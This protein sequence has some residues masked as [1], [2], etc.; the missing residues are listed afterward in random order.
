MMGKDD[1]NQEFLRKLDRFDRAG[2]R[3]MS[4]ILLA[5]YILFTGGILVGTVYYGVREFQ[6]NGDSEQL[7][8]CCAMLLILAAIPVCG[9]LVNH[10]FKSLDQKND[11]FDPRTM[12]LPDN[13]TVTLE[14]TL[15]RMSTQTGAIVWDGILGCVAFSL[16]LTLAMGIGNR[17][18]VL[19]ACAGVMILIAVGH[20]VFHLLWKKKS[21]TKKMLRNTAGAI[22]LE[23]PEAYAEAVE[24]SLNRG[25][26]AYEKELILTDEYILGNAEWDIYF[27]PVAI[28]REQIT[29]FVFFYRRMVV[30]GR[31]SRTLGILRCNADGK[32]LADLVLGQRPKTERILKILRHY[33]LS[34][35]EKELEYV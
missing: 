3:V 30:G 7:T 33:Q 34:W 11:A 24:E 35:Q 32:K 15:H 4:W 25:V 17:P 5:L 22:A 29:E 16:L 13:G 23:H 12:A 31:T 1:K 8:I 28:P 18:R 26:L 21:F 19:L 14:G 20:T 27:T 9:K 2:S 6:G 10:F